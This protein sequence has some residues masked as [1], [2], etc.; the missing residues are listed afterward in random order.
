[1]YREIKQKAYE[2]LEHSKEHGLTGK[3]VNYFIVLLIV[4]NVLSVIFETVDSFYS[5]Y[6]DL[7]WA[8]E[9]F[10]VAIFSIEYLARL[11]VCNNGDRYQ[12]PVKGRIRYMLSPL[13]IVDFLAIVPFYLPMLLPLDMRFLRALRLFRLSRIF[14]LTR[15]SESLN[16]T[17]RIIRD[18]KEDLVIT[19]FI[20]TIV[21]IISSTLMYYAEHEAQPEKFDS[22]PNA[23]YWGV[24]TLATVGYGDIYPVTALGKFFSAIIALSGIAMFAL[25]AGIIGSS[26]IEERQKS[27]EKEIE[28]D[29]EKTLE[30]DIE[31]ALEKSD[32]CPHCGK[33][34]LE[35]VSPKVRAGVEKGIEAAPLLRK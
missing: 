16:M 5:Q 6:S 1:M 9:V 19:V 27:R 29:I 23:M 3:A 10:S 12:G 35:P 26:F 32:I 31:N 13:A 17:G 18:R 24:I 21:L 30:T 28:I 33:S 7:L 8:F 14:K 4:L 20:I 11:W 22:I 2:I 25:P 34:R 15:Y